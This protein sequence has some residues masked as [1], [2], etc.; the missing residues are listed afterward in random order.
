MRPLTRSC[1]LL[2]LLG[3][4]FFLALPVFLGICLRSSW[5]PPFPLHALALVHLFFA[6]VRL[7]PTLTLSSHMVW[8]SGRT[9]LF[10]LAEAAPA[11]LLSA[12]SEALRSLFPFWWAQCVQVFPLKSAPFC[13]LFAG[14]SSTNWSAISLLFSCCL[15]LVLSY[16]PSFLFVS[17]SVADLAATVFSLLLLYQTPMGPRTLVSPGE[18]RG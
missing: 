8:C 4:L 2:P 14:F 10:L 18:R 3:R 17:I 6:K 11:C 1:F 7:S 15:A 12:L 9:A 5:S 16:P 13:A